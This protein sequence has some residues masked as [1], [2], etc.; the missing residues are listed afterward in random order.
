MMQ[1]Q[2][3]QGFKVSGNQKMLNISTEATDARAHSLP[4]PIQRWF[5]VETQVLELVLLLFCF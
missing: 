1:G 2:V 4:G 5:V 3:V